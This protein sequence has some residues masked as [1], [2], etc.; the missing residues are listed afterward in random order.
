MTTTSDAPRAATT[1]S[2]DLRRLQQQL[3]DAGFYRGELDG[4]TEVGAALRDFRFVH[5]LGDDDTVD[6]AT[7]AALDAGLRL[8]PTL[9]AILHD[10]PGTTSALSLVGRIAFRHPDYGGALSASGEPQDVARP[11]RD[12]LADV[13]TLFRQDA[14]P[15]LDGRLVIVGLALLVL[16]LADRL[17]GFLEPVAKRIHE[18]LDSLLSPRGLA[19]QRSTDPQEQFRRL[20]SSSRDA[21]RRAV[22]LR[23]ADPNEDAVHTEHLVLGLY[24]PSDG[25]VRAICDEA[26]LGPEDMHRVL[27]E[28]GRRTFPRSA[29]I[30][31]PLAELPAHS[32]HVALALIAAVRLADDHRVRE[33]G[34]R[35]LFYGL[36]TVPGCHIADALIRVG[37]SPEAVA[38]WI[39]RAGVQLIAVTS[40]D[41]VPPPGEHRVQ[42]ADRLRTADD[43]E[44]LV[45]VLLARQTPLPLAIGLF[46]EWGGGKSFFM[47]LMEELVDELA[48]RAGKGKEPESALFCRNVAQVRFNAWHYSDTNLWASLAYRIFEGLAGGAGGADDPAEKLTKARADV[49]GAWRKREVLERETRTLEAQVTRRR[50]A[51]ADYAGSALG[52]LRADPKLRRTW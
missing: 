28:A 14:A 41:T 39:V 11:V 27:D 37:L 31:D 35:Y 46:G 3:R 44:M 24:G 40:A 34:T 22:G 8:T 7:S 4:R 30:S 33:V 9:A 18:P 29:P 48:D 42:K 32:R 51:L 23:L 16:D 38:A 25:S 6:D 36:L 45:A 50:S 26:G 10:V 12:W 52:E 47:A 13:R 20:S 2:G 15:E 1:G 21:L 19:L 17:T 43:V 5:G 49:D